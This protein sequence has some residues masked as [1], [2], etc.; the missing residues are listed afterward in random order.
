MYVDRRLA[1]IQAVQ[2]LSR[3]NRAYKDKSTTY[4]VDF[5]NDTDEIL[6]AFRTYYATAQ[7][8]AATDP[9]IVYNLRA[10]LDAAG[11]YDSFEV[12]RV[13]AAELK[14]KATQGDLLRA[15]EPIV[16]R[17]MKRYQAAQE[18]LRIAGDTQDEAATKAARDTQDALVLFRSDMQTFIRLYTFLSQ[19]FDYGNTDVEKRAIFYKR[20]VPQLEFGRER[21]GI[22]LSK[23]KLTHHNLRDLGKRTLPLGGGDAPLLDPLSES[24]SGM[25]H[26]PQAVYMSKLIQKLNELFGG[27]T[28]DQD[29][30]VY[31]N[32]VIKGKLMESATLKEQ[33][34]NNSKE[35]FGNSPDLDAELSNAIIDALDAH[36]SMST[37]ALNSAAVRNGIKQILLNH[38]HL[39]EA[40]RGNPGP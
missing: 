37:Q 26:E 16:D 23:V 4:V 33:A 30:L 5:V 20:L 29:Q 10:K 1:C 14:P 2:T 11:H 24:A 7:L 28:T 15:I 3:L 21:E 12:D 6:A 36:T 22:D 18:A 35:Q 8:S 19:I 31:V 17:L 32:Q 39:W 34:A 13:V 25:L 40:L 38:T 27:E 9:N